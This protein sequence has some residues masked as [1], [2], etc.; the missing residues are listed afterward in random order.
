M[1]WRGIY[2][3]QPARLSLRHSC[4]QLEKEDGNTLDFSLEDI[5]YLLLE[6]PQITITS[7][8]LSACAAQGCIVITCNEKHLPNGT[9]LPSNAYYQ[10]LQT[11]YLQLKLS[12]PRQKRLWQ[13]IVKA[14]IRNQATCLRFLGHIQKNVIQVASLENKVKSG[15]VDNIEA[16]AARRYWSLYAP[17]NFKRNTESEDLLNAMLNYGYALVRAAISRELAMRGFMPALGIHHRGKNNPFNLADDLIEPWRPL[18]DAHVLPIWQSSSRQRELGSK[19]KQNIC[20]VLHIQVQ[21]N[22]GQFDFLPALQAYMTSI[23]NYYEGA[24]GAILFPDFPAQSRGE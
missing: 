20:T 14:K 15:D 18:V 24:K 1:S 17:E 5:H 10:Q 22:A 2:L 21:T 9:L 11:L 13:D 23:K 4:L 12:Q 8:L 16:L 3:S 19:D 6:S 7:A